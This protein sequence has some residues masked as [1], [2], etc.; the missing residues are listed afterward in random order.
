MKSFWDELFL[1]GHGLNAPEKLRI[2]WFA[3]SLVL[4]GS[5]VDDVAWWV[6]LL[7]VANFVASGMSMISLSKKMKG[8]DKEEI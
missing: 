3:V 8:D 5:V 2:W 1:K 6:L 4:T 7:L